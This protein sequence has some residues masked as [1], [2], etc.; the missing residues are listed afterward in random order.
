MCGTALTHFMC[1]RLRQALCRTILSES[2]SNLMSLSPTCSSVTPVRPREMAATALTLGSWSSS[3]VSRASITAGLPNLAGGGGEDSG[4]ERMRGEGGGGREEGDACGYLP[5]FS[6]AVSRTDDFM[7]NTSSMLNFSTAIWLTDRQK[8]FLFLDSPLTWKNCSRET[9]STPLKILS[10]SKFNSHGILSS[11][12]RPGGREG[13]GGGRWGGRR[14]GR[15]DGG[16]R[17]GVECRLKQDKVL[18][19]RLV[20]IPEHQVPT[21]TVQ[22]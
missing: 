12:N 16:G 1:P 21:S 15:E 5:S 22:G 8:A 6:I 18:T 7:L 19:K 13:E 17:S 4:R 9:F 3:S 2:F 10:F 20:S 11:L 14:E